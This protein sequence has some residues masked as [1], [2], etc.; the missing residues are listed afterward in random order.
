MRYTKQGCMKLKENYFFCV[1][2]SI[3]KYTVLEKIAHFFWNKQRILYCIYN[4]LT[5]YPM[6]IKGFH[7]LNYY[8]Q[9]IQLLYTRIIYS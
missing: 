8:D 6:I 4:I 2:I 5:H 9:C 3:Y 1:S 7:V